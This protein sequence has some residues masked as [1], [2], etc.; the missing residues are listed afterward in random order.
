MM[1][2][3]SSTSYDIKPWRLV[4]QD[5]LRTWINGRFLLVGDAAHPVHPMIGQGVNTSIE[6]AAALQVLL[7]NIS[8]TSDLKRRLRVFENLRRPRTA[9]FQFLSTVDPGNEPAVREEITPYLEVLGA[10][11]ILNK[12]DSNAFALGYVSFEKLVRDG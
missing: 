4:Y 9:V 11:P 12:K 3:G 10:E 7:S 5:P 8:N 2:T 6:D 1:Q